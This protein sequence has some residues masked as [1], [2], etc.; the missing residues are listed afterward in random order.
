M[1][2]SLLFTHKTQQ[3]ID[4]LNSAI[5]ELDLEGK[6]MEGLIKQDYRLASVDEAIL[7]LDRLKASFAAFL[8]KLSA[9]LKYRR[10]R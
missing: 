6:E 2:V 4:E 10:N 3:Q 5:V 9:G 1:F 8:L 7:E